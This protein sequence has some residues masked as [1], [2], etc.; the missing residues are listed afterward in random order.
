VNITIIGAGNM[1]AGYGRLFAR[2]GHR[3]T[4]TFARDP[5]KLE[6]AALASGPTARAVASSADA[7]R[8]A[9]VVFLAVPYQQVPAAR[10][11]GRCSPR[12]STPSRAT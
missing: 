3:V 6:A 5:R 10:C 8:D 9:D 11:A 2:A 12:P 4:Y 7:V 1:G